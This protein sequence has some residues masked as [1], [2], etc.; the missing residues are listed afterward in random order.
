M[1]TIDSSGTNQPTGSE[2]QRS[3]NSNDGALALLGRVESFLTKAEQAL[4]GWLHHPAAQEANQHIQDAK[5][6]LAAT[7]PAAAADQAAAKLAEA[8]T[9]TNADAAADLPGD[10]RPDNPSAEAT[11]QQENT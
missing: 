10:P 8:P 4:A 3:G 7:L 11:A 5:Q 6:H 1:S 9:L 2:P